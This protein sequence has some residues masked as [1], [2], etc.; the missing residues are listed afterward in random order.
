MPT[1]TPH[2]LVFQSDIQQLNHTHL[3]PREPPGLSHM[4]RCQLAQQSTP[5]QQKPARKKTITKSNMLA[6][7]NTFTMLVMW[8]QHLNNPQDDTVTLD[9]A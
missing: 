7:A 8:V 3:L 9:K 2:F 5:A 1:Y 4:T 6:A